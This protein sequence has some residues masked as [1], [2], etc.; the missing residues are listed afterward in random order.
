MFCHYQYYRGWITDTLQSAVDHSDEKYQCKKM[1]D[2]PYTGTNI[3][4][5]VP[6]AGQAGADSGSDDNKLKTVKYSGDG[7]HLSVPSD[8]NQT[9]VQSSSRNGRAFNEAEL[10]AT[11]IGSVRRKKP[12]LMHKIKKWF[13]R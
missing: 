8:T 11:S 13:R 7:S 9:P 5:K 10:E 3:L 1:S 6:W 12:G 4:Q 2:C